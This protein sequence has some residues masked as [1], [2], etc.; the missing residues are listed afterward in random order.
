M[1]GDHEPDRPPRRPAHARRHLDGDIT[2]GL[3]T[4]IGVRRRSTTARR[5]AAAQY[6]DVSMLDCQVAILENALA[7]YQATGE[8]PGPLGSRHPSIAP[9]AAFATRDGHVVIAAG[10]DRLFDALCH[11]PRARGA[12]A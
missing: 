10:N 5:P 7:R 6:V 12:L 1:R 2:A 11:E 8:T 3:F 9:F 4:A